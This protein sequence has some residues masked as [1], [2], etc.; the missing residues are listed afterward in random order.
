MSF[1]AHKEWRFVVYVVPLYNIAAAHGA[2]TLFFCFFHQVQAQPFVGKI[3]LHRRKRSIWGK[4][5]LL[6][7]A[8][9]LVLNTA[10]TV[11]LTRAS[12]ANHPD[13]RAL[14]LLN[15][16]YADSAHGKP[17]IPSPFAMRRSA[18]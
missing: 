6:I 9:V 5:A 7:V 14:T 10:V 1:L 18:N 12:M 15:E 11:L 2:R 17:T 8:G 4:L 16:R 3:S 13:S